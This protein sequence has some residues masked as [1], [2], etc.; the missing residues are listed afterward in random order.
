MYASPPLRRSS[1]HAVIGGVCSGVA[2]RYGL[3]ISLAR[4]LTLLFCVGTGFGVVLYA[5]A[6]FIVPRADPMLERDPPPDALTRSASRGMLGGV[7]AGI[8]RT[9]GTDVSVIRL[10]FAAT[11]LCFGVGVIPYL[12]AWALMPADDG[13]G[14]WVG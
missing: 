4:I 14:A 3:S 8:S 2:I 7:C 6:W 12:A 11:F 5:L 10:A 13:H 9:T 1:R